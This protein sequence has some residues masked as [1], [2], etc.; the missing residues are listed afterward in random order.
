MQVLA[1]VSALVLIVGAAL[2]APSAQPRPAIRVWTRAIATVLAE[3]GAQFERTAGYRLDVS[4]DLSSGFAEPPS[5][6][7]ARDTQ[8]CGDGEIS[9]ALHQIPK[10]M[11]IPL[12][13]AGRG[14]HAD[15]SSA[16]RSR[17][18]NA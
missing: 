17:R 6:R 4:S 13:R 10:P 11:V 5:R 15:E 2:T 14:R 3:V 12:L 9:G 1:R 18:S 8:I 16:I 7:R